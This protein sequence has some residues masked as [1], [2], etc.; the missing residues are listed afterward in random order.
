MNHILTKKSTKRKRH[1]RAQ[2]MVESADAALLVGV[3]G[4]AELLAQDG[5]VTDNAGYAIAGSVEDCPL[6]E[7]KNQSSSSV[8]G[9]EEEVKAIAGGFDEFNNVI[10]N[11]DLEKAGVRTF[12]S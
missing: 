3:A 11:I 8:D 2:S 6:E 12:R 5:V 9:I 7:V 10:Q 1:L 4:V